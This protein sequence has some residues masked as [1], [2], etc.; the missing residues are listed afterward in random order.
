MARRRTAASLAALAAS[1]A[2]A[3]AAAAGVTPAQLLAQMSVAA[4]IGQMTQL[5][6][7]TITDASNAP[8]AAKMAAVFGTWGV[9]SVINSPFAGACGGWGVGDWRAFLTAVQAAV[10]NYSTT[11]P[12]I[13]L[14]FGLDSVHGAN[15]I[16]N[17]TLFPHNTGAAATF[18][19]P[20]YALQGAITALETRA[21]GI[22]WMFS[23]VLGLGRE[24]K[25]PRLYETLGEDPV[26][27]AAFATAYMTGALA[28]AHDLAPGL[29]ANVTPC[30]PCMKH[31]MGYSSPVSG[32]DRTDAWIPDAY[33]KQY[34]QPAFAAAVAAGAPTTMINSA[35]I[36]GVPAH[37]SRALL[38]DVLRTELGFAG[39]AVTDWQD[40]GA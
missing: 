10:A 30:A 31:Y 26:V 20:L 38:T 32:K 4:K 1:G 34:F 3:A 22:P 37:A 27:G 5:N 39:V 15:Y 28:A 35:S 13:P 17:A 9:G 12:P 33:L 25:W 40:I 29:P 6:I 14:L 2:A 24:M 36:N 16:L 21:A 19:P 23:P 18:N 8:D 11:T 7:D